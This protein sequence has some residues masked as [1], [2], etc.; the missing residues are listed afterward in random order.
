[1]TFEPFTYHY[2]DEVQPD[3]SVLRRPVLDDPQGFDAAMVEQARLER[4]AH[5]KAE[6]KMLKGET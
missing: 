1:M 3:G 4:I 5:L 2:E 6:L